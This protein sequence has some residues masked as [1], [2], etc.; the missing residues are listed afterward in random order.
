MDALGGVD[1][2]INNADVAHTT[3]PIIETT[4]DDVRAMVT[5][6]MLGTVYDTQV[7]VRG[8]LAQG[9]G[10]VFNILGGGSDG[11]IPCVPRACHLKCVKALLGRWRAFFTCFT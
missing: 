1:L 5:T 2:W 9:G 6:N 8:M 11:S 10:Q 7:A 3:L 4:P